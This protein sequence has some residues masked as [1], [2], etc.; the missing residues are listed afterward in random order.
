MRKE[1]KM[2]IVA[3]E[4]IVLD[5]E[6]NSKSEA[7]KAI[8]GIMNKANRLVS[9]NK[10]EEAIFDRENTFPTSIGFQFAIPHGKTDAVSKT[11]VAFARLKNPVQWSEEEEAKFIFMIGVSESQAGNEHLQILAKLSRMI[12][13]EEFRASVAA[14]QSES[15]MLALLQL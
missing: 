3:K 13:R 5:L 15:E 6:A 4:I 8:S 1:L 7:I 10:F 2:G 12:M 9:Q 11:S 14:A